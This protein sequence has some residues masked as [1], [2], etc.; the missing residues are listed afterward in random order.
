MKVQWVSAPNV[1]PAASIATVVVTFMMKLLEVLVTIY[2]CL[3]NSSS[4]SYIIFTIFSNKPS[5]ICNSFVS[6]LLY[7]A[8]LYP[9]V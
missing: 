7:M 3:K 9:I 5:K 2:V 6:A 4:L 8:D 1:A